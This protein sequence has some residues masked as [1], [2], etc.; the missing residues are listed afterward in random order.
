M[1]ESSAKKEV[2]AATPKYRA[3]QRW[4]I[5][6]VVPILAALIGG[7]L[8]YRSISGQGP[9]VEV[10]FETAD[11][12]VAGQTEVRCRSVLVGRVENVRLAED[13]Q[14]VTVELR[15]DPEAERLLR[16]G[17]QFWVVRPRV[18]V[19]DISGLG[20]LIT[21]AYIELDP[22]SG[23]EVKTAY[24]GRETPPATSR[25]IPGRRLVLTA[26][27]AGSLMPGSPIYYR[28]YEVGRIES[29]QL[30]VD[31]MRVTYEAFIREE[32][33]DLVK[34]N[35][36]FWNASGFDL[37]VGADGVKVRTASLQALVSGGAEFGVPEG[38]PTGDPVPDGTTFVLHGDIDEAVNS[39]F[40]PTMKFLLLFDQSVRGLS[41]GAPV[42]F[43]GIQI[44][45]VAEISFERN[46]VREDRRIPVV[47]EIDP[48]L[49]R[50]ETQ[51]RLAD[52]EYQFL[53]GAVARGL[54]ASMKTGNL[55]TGALFVDLDYYPDAPPEEIVMT[56]EFKTLP[57]VSSGLAQLEAKL[58]AILDK[59]Q[60]LPLEGTVEKI[61][62][63]SDEAAR[64]IAE[65]RRTMLEIEETLAAAR[66]TLEDPEFRGLPAELKKTLAELQSSVASVGPEG[67]VQ[68]D[69]LRTLDELRASLRSLKTLTTTLEDKPSSLIFG[70]ESSG[71]VVP[72][73]P[74]R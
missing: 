12:I 13:L 31:G 15:L 38:Q 17:T 68:G 48:L 26:Q 56:G 44:G 67:A 8:V 42:E 59:V 27:E 4:N 58:S 34:Q 22:G 52:P 74:R 49:L 25:S 18:S 47:I 7:W 53:G 54:R 39:T 64:T 30:D 60:A 37:T 32:Y 73:A 61:A 24:V 23:G 57:T 2:A 11:G 66:A 21:G 33:A 16:E 70:R 29:R 50:T 71:N 35:T 28:G 45:R 36:R 10:R 46:P 3:A 69:L 20:T 43:R 5:I 62:T 14:S 40:L 19:N 51:E 65:A 55:L 6:W 9:V 1:S 72:K 63:A 41:A